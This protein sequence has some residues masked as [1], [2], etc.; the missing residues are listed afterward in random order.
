[1]EK[2]IIDKTLISPG[3]FK[4]KVILIT[5]CAGDGP[6]GDIA[7][8]LAILEAKV[9]MVGS[10]EAKLEQIC[11]QVENEMCRYCIPK[12][13]VLKFISNIEFNAAQIV[14]QVTDLYGKLDVLINFAGSEF[15][16]RLNN[17]NCMDY[18]FFGLSKLAMQLNVY[19]AQKLTELALPLLEK[20]KGLV[21]NIPV[22]IQ[23]KP[24]GGQVYQTS[25]RELEKYTSQIAEKLRPKG[26]R[27]N[28]I[29]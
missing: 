11:Q 9:I 21:I 19:S 28:C 12:T 13:I 10:N 4:G 18:N 22:V 8:K 20:A 27:V 1:M 2:Y 16:D 5:G 15:E 23:S 24:Y 6:S 25:K 17:P 3:H 29:K 26:I 7:S 14:Q